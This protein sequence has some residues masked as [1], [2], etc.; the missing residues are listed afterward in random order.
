MICSTW[1]IR[2]FFSFQQTTGIVHVFLCLLCSNQS[3][4]HNRVMKVPEEFFP[5]KEVSLCICYVYNF[6]QT[7]WTIDKT[8]VCFLFN[9]FRLCSW[10]CYIYIRAI[11]CILLTHWRCMD[12]PRLVI[13]VEKMN[14]GFC[15]PNRLTIMPIFLVLL[16]SGQSY[17]HNRVNKVSNG[18]SHS[19]ISRQLWVFPQPTW[20]PPEFIVTC[21]GKLGVV[22]E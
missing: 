21:E 19:D 20:K 5:P 2:V 3:Y 1:C 15:C 18:F 17:I 7:C 13:F 11:I 4:I 14:Y 22:V 12:K 16:C 9:H 6:V 10:L 8:L